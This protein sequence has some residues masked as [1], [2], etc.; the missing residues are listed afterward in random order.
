[1]NT[2]VNFAGGWDTVWGAVSGQLGGVATLLTVIGMLMVL[3]SVLAWIYQ[4]RRGANM[5]GLGGVFVVLFIGAVMAAPGAI[6]PGILRI[7][8][9]VANGLIALVNSTSRG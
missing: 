3:F 5:Q 2:K 7:I 6:I 1:M 8:D 4:K 9:W